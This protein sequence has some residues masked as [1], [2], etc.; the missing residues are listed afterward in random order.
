MCM[1][2]ICPERSVPNGLNLRIVADNLHKV[3]GTKPVLIAEFFRE[4]IIHV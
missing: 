3:V 1:S 4:Q 2:R